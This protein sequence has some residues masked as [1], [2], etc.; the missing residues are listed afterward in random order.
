[1]VWDSLAI[2]EY[3]AERHRA[4]WPDDRVARAFARS[5]TAEMHSGFATLRS[6]MTMCIRERVDV[7]PWSPKLQRDIERIERIFDDTRGRFGQGGDFLFGRYCIADC[8]FAPVAFRF[9][10]Y[11]VTLSGVAG[12][13]VASLLA[14]A[15]VKAWERDALAET[16]IID[17]DEPRYI[18]RDK[19]AR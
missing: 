14:H 6:D 13:Y 4:M 3:L 8:F 5:I 1:M 17:A 15:D 11:G 16:T 9:Q 12:A 18:Y 19:L 2:A 10:T 7:R